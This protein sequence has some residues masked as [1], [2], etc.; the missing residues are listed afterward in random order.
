MNKNIIKRKKKGNNG[1]CK[2]LNRINKLF[3]TSNM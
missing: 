1:L 3:E 2:Q